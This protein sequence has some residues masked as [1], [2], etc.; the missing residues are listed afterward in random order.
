MSNQYLAS[1][2]SRAQTYLPQNQPVFSAVYRVT[3]C[4][5]VHRMRDIQRCQ[6]LKS[7]CYPPIYLLPSLPPTLTRRDNHAPLSSLVQSIL[8]TTKLQRD[9][10]GVTARSLRQSGDQVLQ[11]VAPRSFGLLTDP[12][13][14]QLTHIRRKT[15]PDDSGC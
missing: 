15:Y 7:T 9:Y 13:N 11:Q 14:T 8:N 1:S 3:Q 10:L 12:I 2:N 6:N 4:C 5:L